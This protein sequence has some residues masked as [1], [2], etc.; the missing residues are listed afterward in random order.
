MEVIINIIKAIKGN[1]FYILGP[2]LGA[3]F[4]Y[5]FTMKREKIRLKNEQISYINFLIITFH[6]YQ[7]ELKKLYE[8]VEEKLESIKHLEKFSKKE[9]RLPNNTNDDYLRT[10]SKNK[11]TKPLTINTSN[12]S[13]ATIDPDFLISL[14]EVLRNLEDLSFGIDETNKFSESFCEKTKNEEPDLEYFITFLNIT[15]NN[16]I[17]LKSRICESVCRVSVCEKNLKKFNEEYLKYKLI[18]IPL[19]DDMQNFLDY[20]Q[21]FVNQMN[22][23]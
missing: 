12:F 16:H 18:N 23:N 9:N 11:Y 10:V 8:K 14:V 5:K 4:A 21:K 20:C 2:F 15:Y 19:K 7:D 1:F 3:W 17:C 6:S 22:T 13:F